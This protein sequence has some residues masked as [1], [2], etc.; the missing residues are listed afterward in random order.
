LS[1]GPNGPGFVE[2]AK[3]ISLGLG[4]DYQ[5]VYKAK[6]SYTNSFGNPYRNIS[7]DKDFVAF[8]VSYAF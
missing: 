7:T 4:A 6:L 1:A 2:R 5:G 3:T 8:N